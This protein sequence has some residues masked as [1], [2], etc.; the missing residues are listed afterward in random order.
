[1]AAFN[2]KMQN[3]RK[4]AEV[5]GLKFYMWPYWFYYQNKR[6]RESYWPAFLKNNDKKNFFTILKEI[7]ILTLYWKCLPHHYFRYSLYRKNFDFKT[8][9]NYIPESVVYYKILPKINSYHI[10]LDD[11]NLFENILK[12]NNLPTPNTLLKIRK[13]L[14]LNK[15]NHPISSEK[16]IEKILNKTEV[17]KIFL[18]PADCG[19][20]GEEIILFR[21]KRKKYFSNDCKK[22]SL[23]MLKEKVNT[24]WII[25]EG[26]ENT[27]SL[28][29]IHP[30][31]L[32][33]F[34]V[35]TFF[36]P[37]KGAKVIYAIL[38]VGNN[39]AYTD[40][41]HTGGIYIGVNLATGKLMNK[42]FNEDL[43]EY[44]SH[45]LTNYDFR[46]KKIKHF[47]KIIKIAERAGNLFP[48]LTFIGWDIALTN[49]GPIIL[50]G[51]SSPGLTIIQRTCGGIKKFYN[52][53]N[54]I[55]KNNYLQK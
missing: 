41:A 32:N 1:M 37:Q 39:N 27:R 26:I 34:R 13:G 8:I 20:G 15:N 21:K 47:E 48:Y 36:Y 51:N 7:W 22:L 5:F 11:K 50:E 40:N 54:D 38:K 33:T 29:K 14:I 30:S 44:T 53:A 35:M 49:D 4:K 12:S 31:S 42:G 17:S 6:F 46:N 16:E 19:S 28:K 25:Q 3:F 9:L 43:K 45:P 52:L 18:K 24:D 10:L 55:I 23:K 2:E